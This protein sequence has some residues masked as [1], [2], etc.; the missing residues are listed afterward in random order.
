[1]PRGIA[2][3][4]VGEQLFAAAERVLLRDG[5]SGLTSRAVTE[6]AGCAKGVL[7]N[8]FGDFDGFL[9]EFVLDRTRRIADQVAELHL[10]AGE[11]H[12][13]A[14]LTDAV[15]SVFGPTAMGLFSLVTSRASL[16]DRLRRVSKTG[17][18]VLRD[19]EVAFGGYLEAEKAHGRLAENADSEV[20]AFALVGSAHRLFASQAGGE[21]DRTAVRRTVTAVIGNLVRGPEDG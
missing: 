9:A 5:P 15:L 3:T 17:E 12:V 10:A 21:L 18:P 11:N 6:E 7:H 19:V 20:L 1:M 13:V 14:N 2:L 16:R 4:E 8:H